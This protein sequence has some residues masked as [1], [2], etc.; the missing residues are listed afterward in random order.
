MLRQK[1][2]EILEGHPEHIGI[3]AIITFLVFL[4]VAPFLR[5]A[6]DQAAPHNYEIVSVTAGAWPLN[7]LG[8]Q[9]HGGP[10]MWKIRNSSGVLSNPQMSLNRRAE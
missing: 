4:S 5:R 3:A 2:R 6:L 9:F 8:Y 7:M 10:G 1:L